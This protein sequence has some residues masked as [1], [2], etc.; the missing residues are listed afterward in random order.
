MRSQTQILFALALVA[1][2]ATT[3]FAQEEGKKKKK[4]KDAAQPPAITQLMKRT[5]G[6][7]LSEE[8]QKKVKEIADSYAPKFAEQNQKLNSLLT[9]EQKKARQEAVAKNKAD[10]KKGKE[11][12]EAINT[13][14]ALTEEQKKTQQEVQAQLKELTKK[15]NDEVAAVLTPEQLGKFTPPKGKK[16]A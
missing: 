14:M 8:Q 3:S 7:G 10:G 13:A 15:L 12:N 5:E 16:A 11:A 4:K 6:L 1:L 9:E 2:V